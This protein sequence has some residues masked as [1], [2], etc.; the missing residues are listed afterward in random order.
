VEFFPGIL[1]LGIEGRASE[2]AFRNSRAFFKLRIIAVVIVVLAIRVAAS[3]GAGGDLGYAAYYGDL[4]DV[5]RLLA[6]GAQVD[7]REK[8]GITAL[9]A[10]CL[11]GHREIVGL[12]LANGAEVNAK[13]IDGETPLMYAS[14]RGDCNIAAM[15]LTRGAAVNAKTREGKTALTFATRMKH[16]LVKDLLIAAGAK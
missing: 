11:E 4:S 15:L 2:M 7:A 5:K 6:A 1:I 10:A 3:Q 12:L 9:M 13:T 14:I 8:N 16:P